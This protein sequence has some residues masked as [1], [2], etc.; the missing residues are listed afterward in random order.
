MTVPGAAGLQIDVDVKL[1]VF[2]LRL[3]KGWNV[4]TLLPEM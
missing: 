4:F 3:N 2:S 1:T